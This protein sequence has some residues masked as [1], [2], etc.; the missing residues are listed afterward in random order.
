MVQDIVKL[1]FEVFLLCY[2]M[3]S[4]NPLVSRCTA[5]RVENFT[6]GLLEILYFLFLDDSLFTNVE[7]IKFLETSL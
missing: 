1:I 5:K 7:E 6:A 4:S 3:C 2:K